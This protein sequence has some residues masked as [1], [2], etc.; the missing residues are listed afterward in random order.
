LD[1]YKDGANF[2]QVG[3]VRESSWNGRERNLLFVNLGEGRFS[4]AARA[5]GCDEVEETR[6]VAMAD[7]DR[8]GRLD[9][10]MSNNAAAPTIYL[11]RLPGT[12]NWC[13]F[14]LLGRTQSES[15]TTN[16]DALGTRV[17]ATVVRNGAV[18][19]LVR[20]TTAGS[21]YAAQSQTGVHFGLGVDGLLTKLEITWPSGDVAKLEQA[22]LAKVLNGEWIIQEGEESGLSPWHAAT[23]ALAGE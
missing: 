12:G 1:E 2:S 14:K 7:L 9:I 3:F 15:P 20:E 16:R 19:R 10:I 13:R 17:V 5:M 23:P 18:Q 4:D 22:E 6:G 11:N 8:D 21:G